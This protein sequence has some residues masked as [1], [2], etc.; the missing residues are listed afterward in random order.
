METLNAMKRLCP[1]R[2]FRI[3]MTDN[4][5]DY[6]DNEFLIKWSKKYNICLLR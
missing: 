4:F 5:D 3:T 1:T 2:A 6:K